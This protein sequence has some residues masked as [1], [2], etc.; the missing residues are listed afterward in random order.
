MRGKNNYMGLRDRG[1]EGPGSGEVGRVSFFASTKVNETL[2][3]MGCKS[4][5][6]YHLSVGMSGMMQ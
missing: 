2:K 3:V 6:Q 4:V 5:D 1:V